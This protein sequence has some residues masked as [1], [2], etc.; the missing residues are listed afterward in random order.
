MN[1]A[2]ALAALG[3]LAAVSPRALAQGLDAQTFDPTVDGHHFIRLD[4]SLVGL[5]GPGGG[6]VFNY[7]SDPLVFR[8]DEPNAAPEGVDEA[9]LLSSV[10]TVNLLGFYNVRRYRIG[11]DVPLNPTADGYQLA[12]GYLLGDIA[13][14]AKAELIDRYQRPVGL[15]VAGRVSAP[16]GNDGAYLGAAQPTISGRVIAA[17]GSEVI[18]TVN[19]GFRT[20]RSEIE[21]DFTVGSQLIG[22]AGFRL[23]LATQAWLSAEAAGS[24]YFNASEPVEGFAAE[25]LASLHVNP[26]EPLVFTMGG[27]LGLS[28]GV[29]APD[30]RVLSGLVWSPQRE[31]LFAL[32]ADGP[33]LDADGIPDDEDRCPDQPEDYNGV[34]DYDG[35]PDGQWTPTTLFVIGPQGSLVAGSSI[36]L[37]RGP[38][39]GE[40][41][42]EAGE[43]T[44]ALLPGTYQLRIS[45]EGFEDNT[46]ELIVPGGDGFEQRLHISARGARDGHVVV[47]VTDADGKSIMAS[48]R[49]LG[50]DVAAARASSDG[51]VE[52]ALLPG[53][54][55]LVVAADGYKTVRRM[56]TLREGSESLVDIVLKPSRIEVGVDQISLYDRIFFEYD[57][58]VIKRES[59]A[60]LDELA[61]T[62]KDYTHI[63]L[64]EIQGHTDDRGSEMYNLDLSQ[65]R[66]DSVRRYLVEAGVSQ[67]RLVARGYGEGSPLR[68][69]DHDANRRVEFHILK[70]QR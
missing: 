63:S 60:I 7:A 38:V 11:V 66:A 15:A 9:V 58:D 59:F 41:V 17:T 34:D 47:H 65:R 42:T 46:T 14:D 45:A 23:P 8:F 1:R 69:G 55:E 31:P 22:G 57:S 48:V 10:A 19:L 20:G 37:V 21:E 50:E 25:A 29:G 43:L 40:W 51:V 35:C 30:F 36:E 3:L 39:T 26:I 70:Q 28:Q 62:L 33:D 12:D 53:S 67:A 24:Y 2:A 18:T 54:H 68:R 4:D 5:Q 32:L 64:V 44:R 27:G 52:R 16:T 13:I 56:V 49:V 61:D 6:F